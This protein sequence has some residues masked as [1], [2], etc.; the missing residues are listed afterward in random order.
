MWLVKGKGRRENCKLEVGRFYVR[1]RR[2]LKFKEKGR[3]S[4]LEL[5][6]RGFFIGVSYSGFLFIF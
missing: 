6:L 4:F 3:G 1:D 5:E 2:K